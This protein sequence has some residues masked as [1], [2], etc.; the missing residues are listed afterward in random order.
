[1]LVLDKSRG[2]RYMPKLKR[3][4][5][6]YNKNKKLDMER[7]RRRRYFERLRLDDAAWAE[8]KRKDRER[9]R[10]HRANKRKFMETLSQCLFKEEYSEVK[11][12]SALE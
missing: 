4:S 1:M 2:Y 6:R 12:E 7:D 8:K 5:D 10:R 3:N 11:L 9:Q